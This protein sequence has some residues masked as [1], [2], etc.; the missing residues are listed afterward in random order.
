MITSPVRMNFEEH[1]QDKSKTKD[2]LINELEEMRQ[3]ISDLEKSENRYRTFFD[4]TSEGIYCLEF[5]QGISIHLPVEEQIQKCY[6]YGYLAECN[7][8]MARMYGY[9]CAEEIMGTR[10]VELHG[11][12]DN[13]QNI[14]EW[15]NF[16]LSGYRVVD[17]ETE[18][19]DKYGNR[20]Y[21]LNNSVGVVKDG[22]FLA[23][24]GTQRNITERRLIEA[25]LSIRNQQYKTFI[26][27]HLFGIW[28]VDFKE[29]IPTTDSPKK[30][31]RAIL[32]TGFMA[33]CN[34]IL[35]GMYGL[36]LKK[37][38]VGK[39]IKELVIDQD[40]FIKRLSKVA[41]N[42]FRAEMVD[43]EEV[44]SKGDVRHFRNSY[45]GYTNDK[46][47]H[48]LWGLQ[49]DITD[50]KRMEEA[51]RESEEKHRILF[52]TMTQGVIYVEENG[53]IRDVNPAAGR[54]LGLTSDQIKSRTAYD[55][56]WKAVR[57]DGSDFPGEIHPSMIALK[58]G[59]EVRNVV[60]GVFRP[61]SK[62]YRWI[63]INSVPQYTSGNTNPFQVYSIFEDIT[64][65]K[66]EED[67]IRKD[68]KENRVLLKEI[69]HRVNNNLKIVGSL[70]SLQA[71]FIEDDDTR[72]IFDESRNRV[73]SIS[74]V[75]EALYR[76]EDSDKIS[77][78]EYIQIL[79]RHLYHVYNPEPGKIDLDVKVEN[80]FLGIDLAVPCGLIINELV[81]NALRHAFPPSFKGKGKIQITLY[82]TESGEIELI[83]KDN[84]I[85]IPENL[86]I[87]NTKSFGMQLIIILA[88]DQLKG[89]VS[90]DRIGET[91]F[92]IR[93]NPEVEVE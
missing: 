59:Q 76:S 70:L 89:K 68:L 58:S 10:L 35:L 41:K 18:E 85:G 42:N 52:E 47:L 86:G 37:E 56:A 39:P 65:R 66:L 38:L 36:K 71:N 26:E 46:T 28:R 84:G 75:H 57:E 62:D 82:P 50:S 78:E 24:W 77:F 12:S 17:S 67:Q 87:T 90:L 40:A 14:K 49:L 45:F 55:P 61:G 5:G 34:E 43:T 92:T 25:Q 88:R 51:L 64:D 93:F 20:N 9:S 44:D 33:E 48:W 29:P 22:Y 53:E 2:Q 3:R 69:H 6:E 81:S 80:I 21:F 32:D 23:S 19:V 60:M 54:I 7:D 16:I 74:L 91:K 11:G 73:H 83:V 15:Q 30:I 79:A 4:Q 27:N 8:V 13:P 31:A 63:N 72:D 1:M